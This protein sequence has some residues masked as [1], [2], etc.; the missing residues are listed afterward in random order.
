MKKQSGI[1]L[2]VLVITII[3]LLILAGVSISMVTGDNGIASKASEAKEKTKT[4]QKK[5]KSELDKSIENIDN[6]LAEYVQTGTTISKGSIELE[7]GQVVDYD[8]TNGGKIT[9]LTDVEWQI[10]GASNGKLLL[11]ATSNV[12]TKQLSGGDGWLNGIKYLDEICEQYGKGKGADTARSIRIDDV[13]RVTKYDVNKGSYDS[14]TAT[15]NVYGYGTQ[16]TYGK[17]VN[18]NWYHFNGKGEFTNSESVELISN[19]YSYFPYTLTSSDTDPKIGLTTNSP[20][21]KLLFFNADGTAADY[22]CADQFVR[23]FD[24]YLNYGIRTVFEDE[25]QRAY[26][27]IEH[28]DNTDTH[29][30]RPVIVLKSSVNLKKVEETDSD[31]NINVSW[32]IQ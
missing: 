27:I 28:S 30:V 29:G 13:N 18:G 12:A 1:T 9:G 5:E 15:Y 8:E 4:S 17:V 3:V 2:I 22:Y 20:E 7:V 32:T 26:M 31:G 11:V 24:T 16:Y 10:L 6:T 25:V 23:I 19:Y 14:T 21:Y